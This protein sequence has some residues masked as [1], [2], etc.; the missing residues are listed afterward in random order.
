MDPE[1]AG[2]PTQALDSANSFH[3]NEDDRT[4]L[5]YPNIADDVNNRDLVDKPKNRWQII[6]KKKRNIVVVSLIA[7][8]LVL[9]CTAVVAGIL[10]HRDSTEQGGNRKV[11]IHA[12]NGAVATELDTCSTIGVKILREGGNAVDAAIASGICIGSI[13]MF[14]AGIGG[15]QPAFSPPPVNT[16]S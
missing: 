12:K 15:S 6:S 4:P 2:H 3:G 10:V 5:L 11:L 13:N 7:T 9:I 16:H 1:S 14:S 8:L